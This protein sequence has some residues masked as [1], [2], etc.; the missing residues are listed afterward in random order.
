V[1]QGMLEVLARRGREGK[2]G[3]GCRIGIATGMV[4]LS[5]RRKGA[6]H[7]VEAVKHSGKMVK[8]GNKMVRLG[9]DV[10]KYSEERS[11]LGIYVC[12]HPSM[13]RSVCSAFRAVLSAGSGQIS[14]RKGSNQCKKGVKLV[15]ERD[16]ISER[17]GVKSGVKSV[18]GGGQISEK[19]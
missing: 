17:R 7:K 10:V 2:P 14:V 16:Q 11:V 6:N 9:N 12:F 3:A 15:K 1:A 5:R 19:H 13:R 18:K 8:L 4:S